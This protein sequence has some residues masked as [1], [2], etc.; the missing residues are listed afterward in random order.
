MTQSPQVQPSAPIALPK[1][2][3]EITITLAAKNL[4]P[5]LLSEQFLKFSGIVANDWELAR[6]AVLNPGGSQ[7]MFKNGLGIVA[8]PRLVNFME[9]MTGKTSGEVLAP[10]VARQFL[11]KL[12]HAEYQGLTI[13]PKCLIPLPNNPDGGRKYITQNLLSPGPWQS[14]GK[15][16]V[17]ASVNFLYQFEGCQLNLSVNQA[18]LQ[19][20][21]QP[22][23]SAILFTGNFNYPV[24]NPNVGDRLKTLEQY[25]SAWQKDVE[26][27]Q[28]MVY[29]RFMAQQQPESLF[30]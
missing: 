26:T 23:V 25:L 18:T 8:Q 30:T 17:R 4:D 22:S 12:P 21:D 28:A 10:E 13:S 6:P 19:I 2:I 27:F 9:T 20:P 3:Q 24:D 1:D 14:F 29:E 16:P 15:A 7:I 5:T 11:A